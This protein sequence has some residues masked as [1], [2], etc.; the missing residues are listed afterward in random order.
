MK[1][2]AF[3]LIELLVAVL[4]IGILAAIAVPQYQKAVLRSHF[5]QMRVAVK[6]IADAQVAY[7]LANGKYST[8][9]TELSL[10][11]GKISSN[12][13]RDVW[14][15]KTRCHLDSDTQFTCH[16]GYS[17]LL[18]QTFILGKDIRRHSCCVYP[19]DNFKGEEL[20]QEFKNKTT[21]NDFCG[22]CHCY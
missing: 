10:D 11:I 14:M 1:N 7:Y 4:I 17:K 13:S 9:F 21:W 8:D 2:K 5:A 6:A 18:I 20:C 15:G 22:G 12:S 3:T 16:F 19:A